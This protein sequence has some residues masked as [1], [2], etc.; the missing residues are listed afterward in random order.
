[1]SSVRRQE[2][3]VPVHHRPSQPASDEASCQPTFLNSLGT[4]ISLTDELCPL[5]I[6]R[7]KP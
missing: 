1:M 5:T 3:E 4:G 7:S 6:A 2:E